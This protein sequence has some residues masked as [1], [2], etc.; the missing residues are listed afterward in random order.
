[1]LALSGDYL[2]PPKKGVGGRLGPPSGW[3]GYEVTRSFLTVWD[4]QTGKVVK[5]WNRG[6]HVA[7]SPTLPILAMVERNGDNETRIGFWDFAPE[8]EKK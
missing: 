6:P 5:S 1:M 8:V 3:G 2:D 7:F 4:T